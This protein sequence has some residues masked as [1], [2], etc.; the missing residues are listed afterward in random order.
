VLISIGYGYEAL[1]LSLG[2][3]L[4]ATLVEA[5]SP[6]GWDNF[7]TQMAACMGVMMVRGLC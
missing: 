3:A 4:L 7:T 1:V 6:H 5:V 2:A